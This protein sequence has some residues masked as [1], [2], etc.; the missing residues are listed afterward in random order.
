MLGVPESIYLRPLRAEGFT[1]VETV[2]FDGNGLTVL[3]TDDSVSFRYIEIA[4]IPFPALFLRL[5]W[6]LGWRRASFSVGKRYWH[7]DH[8]QARMEFFTT[9]R[10][11]I[12]MPAEG[13]EHYATSPWVQIQQRLSASG[14][15]TWDLT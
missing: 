14:F 3:S 4:K 12:W 15:F 11:T 13:H 1:N 6:K 8:R 7:V 2:C 9:P 10:L 5:L